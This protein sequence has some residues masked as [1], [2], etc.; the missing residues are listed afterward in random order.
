MRTRQEPEESQN[1]R[2]PGH[3]SCCRVVLWKCQSEAL[4]GPKWNNAPARNGA[5]R[6]PL[7]AGNRAGFLSRGSVPCTKYWAQR[8]EFGLAVAN[9]S[10]TSCKIFPDMP[11][12]GSFS[13]DI[14]CP[15][16]GA[17]LRATVR[18]SAVPSA[19][20]RWLCPQCEQTHEHDFGGALAQI[21]RRQEPDHSGR[22][23]SAEGAALAGR[24]CRQTS[25]R[26]RLPRIEV[27]GPLT[28]RVPTLG[29]S[30]RV[31]DVSLGGA[32]TSSPRVLEPGEYHSFE[33]TL[34]EIHVR[35]LR[36]YVV[37]CRAR[38]DDDVF[39]VGWSWATDPITEQNARAL[40]DYLTDVRYVRRRP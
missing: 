8:S 30:L 1:R 7:D 18:P 11:G 17:S 28:A 36:A 29:L 27:D 20:A 35:T 34:N 12:A 15:N 16:C 40:V 23:P 14:R 22:V 13:T 31:R 25:L 37:Y 10:P 38:A 21:V 26:P 4:E 6:L 33:I 32:R 24:S 19:P 9:R 3:T 39:T 2:R 5:V